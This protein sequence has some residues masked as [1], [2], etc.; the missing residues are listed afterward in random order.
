MCMKNANIN[1]S[2]F[3]AN[4]IKIGSVSSTAVNTYGNIK[5]FKIAAGTSDTMT[6][7]YKPFV[8][9]SDLIPNKHDVPWYVKKV[10]VAVADTTS[11]TG[12]ARVLDVDL[13]MWLYKN[14]DS[15]TFIDNPL[16][17]NDD[18]YGFT[19]SSA[20]VYGDIDKS[21]DVVR[22]NYEFTFFTLAST[23]CDDELVFGIYKA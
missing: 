16:I 17:H 20:T 23:Y 4:C 14:G 6:F 5:V 1:S 12:Y 15:I 11:A 22:T 2:F 18:G 10:E 8:W 3:T 19:N 9:D 7:N 21:Y 13:S